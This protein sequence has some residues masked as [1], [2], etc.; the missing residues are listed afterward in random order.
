MSLDIRPP[1]M[2]ATIERRPKPVNRASFPHRLD[3]LGQYTPRDLFRHLSAYIHTCWI[4]DPGQRLKGNAFVLEIVN[5]CPSSS[6]AGN[7]PNITGLTVERFLGPVSWS[8]WLNL[9][10]PAVWLAA[11]FLLAMWVFRGNKPDGAGPGPFRLVKPSLVP[12][13]DG[14]SGGVPV[15]VL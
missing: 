4:F 9:G 8:Q 1:G 13:E 15:P 11:S 10:G 12:P 7:Q 2:A 14:W 6:G 3:N 5:D